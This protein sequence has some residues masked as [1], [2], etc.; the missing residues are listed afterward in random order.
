M[1]QVLISSIDKWDLL[2]LQSKRPSI[3]QNSSLQTKKE[4]SSIQLTSDR[5]LISKIYK[6]LK[7]LDAN[8]PNNPI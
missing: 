8:K 4:S 6:E 3:E 1:A 7:K 2:K 5:E